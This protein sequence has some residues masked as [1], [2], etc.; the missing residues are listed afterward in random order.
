MSRYVAFNLKVGALGG[1][2]RHVRVGYCVELGRAEL[3]MG[4]HAQVLG[5]VVEKAFLS[6][7][8]TVLSTA[9]SA[10]RV[11]LLKLLF[12]LAPLRVSR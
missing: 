2:G 5:R 10:L 4:G 12:S 7:S 9:S 1:T 8:S 11:G 6:R 3:R